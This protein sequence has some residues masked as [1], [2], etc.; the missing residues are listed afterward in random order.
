MAKKSKKKAKADISSQL[1]AGGALVTALVF[2]PSTFLL[3]IG[4]LPTLVAALTT[5]KKRL[6]RAITVGAMNLAG[7]SPFLLELWVEGQTFEKGFYIISDPKAVVV[8]YSA[9]AVGYL[10][11]W[12]MSGIVASV[13]F[14]RGQ[15]RKKQIK[16]RQQELVERWGAEVTGDLPIDEYGFPVQVAKKKPEK[17]RND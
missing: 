3:A 15:T 4:M 11:D 12:A 17:G 7:C 6:A 10:V 13:M 16:K 2:L 5:R 1:L 8:M 14:Q 9:A